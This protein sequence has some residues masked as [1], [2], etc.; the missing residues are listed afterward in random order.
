[1]V[2]TTAARVPR[3]GVATQ[4]TLTMTMA[5]TAVSLMDH[6]G[7]SSAD[8]PAYVSCQ[9]SRFKYSA[10]IRLI[11]ALPPDFV[12]QRQLVCNVLFVDIPGLRAEIAVQANK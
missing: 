6:S 9:N 8:A 1:M 7:R 4:I 5:A 11:T 2:N 3:L 12:A 10:N